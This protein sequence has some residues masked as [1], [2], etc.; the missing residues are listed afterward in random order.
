MTFNNTS[1]KHKVSDETKKWVEE[2]ISEQ[3]KRYRKIE[4]QMEALTTEREKWYQEFFDR[5]S[6]R[7]FNQNG[8]DKVPIPKSQ[9]PVKEE[10][11][12]DQVV[13]KYGADD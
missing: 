9:L 11:R 13:W 3:E 8:D 2:E 10:G 4:Q 7:G 1:I 12:K 6:T 5:I